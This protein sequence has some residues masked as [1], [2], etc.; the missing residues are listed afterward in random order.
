MLNSNPSLRDYFAAVALGM[1]FSLPFI[2]EIL[3]DVV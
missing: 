2:V 3:K 1:L